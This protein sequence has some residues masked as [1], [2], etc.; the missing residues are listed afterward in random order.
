MIVENVGSKNNG[1]ITLTFLNEHNPMPKCF[2]VS[3]VQHQSWTHVRVKSA[4]VGLET[5]KWPLTFFLNLHCS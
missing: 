5:P 1:L 2:P 3:N 4:D